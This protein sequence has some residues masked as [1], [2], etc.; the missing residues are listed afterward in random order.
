MKFVVPG[1]NGFIGSHICRLAVNA[2]HEVVAF[3]RSGEPDLLPVRHPWVGK[4]NWRTADVFDV[5]A[6]SDT[7]DGADAVI[8]TI[9]T[10]T[11]DPDNGVTFDRINGEAA[12]VAAEAAAN[13]G[14]SAF[15]KL[16]VQ[17][18][19]P[20]VS[21]RFLA[22]MRRAEREIP[23]R[24]PSLRTVFVQP[25]LVFGDD[26]FG[27]PTM[28]GV[29]QSIGRLVPFDYGSYHGRPLP[30]QLVAATAVQ[31]ATTTTLRGALAVDQIDG[32]GRTS[33]LVQIDEL[34]EPTLRPLL[35]AIGGAALTY[36]TLKRLQRTSS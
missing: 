30:V 9:G 7:L 25:N 12:I 26:R 21:G 16:S 6:W 1:G 20:G 35:A 28:A 5:D 19:P 22:S 2:G 10:I 33:G 36:W 13:A 24:L 11:Q 4:V 15:V 18:K 34:H 14:V 8:H 29:L 32:I 31:A 27:T 17:S 3:G 23:A